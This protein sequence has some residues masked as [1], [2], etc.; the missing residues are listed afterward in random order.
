MFMD[1]SEFSVP[2]AT[3]NSNVLVTVMSAV[4]F[5]PAS[6]PVSSH[7]FLTPV[8]LRCERTL[9]TNQKGTACS[10]YVEW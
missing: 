9:S 10:L 8:L 6:L 2:G 4:H 1:Q 5:L 3:G 7:L